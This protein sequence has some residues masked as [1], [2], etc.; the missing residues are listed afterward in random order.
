MSDPAP[1][2]QAQQLRARVEAELDKPAVV[3][4][5]SAQDGDGKSL[6]ALSLARCFK[7]CDHRV[8]LVSRE[9]SSKIPR[10]RL[11][12]FVEK[13]R[14]DYDF[15]II[16][17][18]TFMNSSNVMALTRLVDGIV[19]AVR[20]GRPPTADDDAMIG[21]IERFGGRVVGVVATEADTNTHP[22]PQP[23]T[24]QSPARALLA[25]AAERLL[26]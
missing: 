26:G 1:N 22:K 25:A 5:T 14:S 17:A 15:T 11:A 24:K 4:V 10:D 20:I 9:E 12:A 2:V 23:D 3:M 7:S 6:T 19:L 18:E 8:V 16:D 13:M 21:M